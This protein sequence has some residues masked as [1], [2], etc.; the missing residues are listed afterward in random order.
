MLRGD[1]KRRGIL[2]ELT[3]LLTRF[4]LKEGQRFSQTSRVR[5][6]EL[7]QMSRV[8]TYQRWK[9]DFVGFFAKTNLGRLS[10]GPK[11]RPSQ[12]EGSKEPA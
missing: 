8:I 5:D 12:K 1:I 9:D 10:I 11:K 7:D 4:L 3:K 6:E 2:P